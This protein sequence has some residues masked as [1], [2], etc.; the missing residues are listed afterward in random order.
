MWKQW[1]CYTEQARNLT[2]SDFG[3]DVCNLEYQTGRRDW[4]K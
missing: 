1:L 4:E 2:E 3:K